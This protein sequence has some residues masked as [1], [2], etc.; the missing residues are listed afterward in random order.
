M[1]ACQS[2]APDHSQIRTGSGDLHGRPERRE[3]ANFLSE[4]CGHDY[5]GTVTSNISEFKYE[6]PLTISHSQFQ[7][8]KLQ[9]EEAI[10]PA[11]RPQRSRFGAGIGIELC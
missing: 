8:G 11:T 10:H 2:Q 4:E 6:N 3:T 7:A 5:G 1:V 9:K